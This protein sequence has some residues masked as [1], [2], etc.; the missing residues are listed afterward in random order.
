MNELLTITN[1]QPTASSLDIAEHFGK[2]HDHVMR[3]IDEIVR[4]L[5]KIGDTPLFFKTTYVHPQNGQEYPMYLMNR[6]GFTLLAMGFTG[7]EALEWKVKYINAFNAMEQELRDKAKKPMTPTE[8]FAMQAQINLDYEKKL[9]ALEGKLENTNKKFDTVANFMTAPYADGD[10][11]KDRTAKRIKQA[12]EE[13]GLNYQTFHKELYD[14]LER[15]AGVD[16]Q[17][18]QT[19]RRNRMWEAGATK[20]ECKNVS[21]LSIVADD[22]KLRAMFETILRNHVVQLAA[23]RGR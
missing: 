12:V 13:F 21:K 15:T 6:D 9:T 22:K 16:L 20:T 18:R 19:R 17:C 8:M 3:D 4:G 23:S 2:R 11:W 7:K 10:A 14:E 5:P 1:G